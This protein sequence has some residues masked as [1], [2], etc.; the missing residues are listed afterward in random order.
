M[1]SERLSLVAVV[2]MAVI[3]AGADAVTSVPAHP[4][5]QR[6]VESAPA[7]LWAKLVGA[8]GLIHDF[9]GEIPGPEDCAKGR[10]NV[11]GWWSPIENGPMFTGLYLPAMC[12]RARRSGDPLDQQQARRLAQGLL[13]CASISDVPGFVAR[14]VGTDGTCHYPLR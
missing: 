1:K 12:E 14:G 13:K 10:P 5:V 11:I 3:A 7:A 2:T 4:D 9:V 6:A 8:D